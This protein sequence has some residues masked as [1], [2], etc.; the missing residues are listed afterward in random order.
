[1]LQTMMAY[2]Q[3]VSLL[4]VMVGKK[5]GKMIVNTNKRLQIL[6]SATIY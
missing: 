1:M 5:N 4:Y 3:S 6:I 2:K